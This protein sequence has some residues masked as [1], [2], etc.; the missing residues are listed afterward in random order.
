L[1]SGRVVQPYPGTAA[2]PCA[3]RGLTRFPTSV[4]QNADGSRAHVLSVGWS[5]ILPASG[6][7][8]GTA[9]TQPK[10]TTQ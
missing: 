3:L 6:R 10:P 8:N 2:A 9:A 7:L 5:G 1:Q 4:T